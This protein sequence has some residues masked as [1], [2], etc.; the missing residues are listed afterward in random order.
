MQTVLKIKTKKTPYL[1]ARKVHGH[2]AVDLLHRQPEA[3]WINQDE[4]IH[5]TRGCL[6]FFANLTN[7]F[8]YVVLS[9]AKLKTVQ[10]QLE[11]NPKNTTIKTKHRSKP[12]SHYFSSICQILLSMPQKQHS[13]KAKCEFY[14]AVSNMHVMQLKCP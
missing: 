4:N 3:K 6:F 9:E 14:I 8:R 12:Y 1:F 13:L 5:T 11:K 7:P 10:K 2:T